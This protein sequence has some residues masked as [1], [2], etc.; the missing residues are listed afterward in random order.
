M[1]VNRHQDGLK[2]AYQ[3]ALEK[4]LFD[5]LEGGTEAQGEQIPW[6][7]DETKRHLIEISEDVR[8]IGEE[9][10]PMSE[11]VGSL[12]TQVET[13]RSEIDAAKKTIGELSD[14]LYAITEALD[15]VWKSV[16]E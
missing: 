4:G 3:I 8:V 1:L 15:E 11:S 5:R 6:T 7:T 13:L 2:R 9:K 10:R 12:Q 16:R 14:L